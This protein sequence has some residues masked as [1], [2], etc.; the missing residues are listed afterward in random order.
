VNNVLGKKDEDLDMMD[1]SVA[2]RSRG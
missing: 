2:K 1:L